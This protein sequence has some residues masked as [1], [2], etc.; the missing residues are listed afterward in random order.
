M[1]EHIEIS[2]GV[3]CLMCIPGFIWRVKTEME[4]EQMT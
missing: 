2:E 4:A 1:L 3:L